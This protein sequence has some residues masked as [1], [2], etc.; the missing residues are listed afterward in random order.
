[1]L[2]QQFSAMTLSTRMR[3]C[4]QEL[5]LVTDVKTLPPIKNFCHLPLPIVCVQLPWPLLPLLIF[6]A[7]L[8]TVSLPP[9][10]PALFFSFLQSLYEQVLLLS[11]HPLLQLLSLFLQNN[12][13]ISASTLL[14]MA[15]F[16][17]PF[18]FCLCN[19]NAWSL[20]QVRTVTNMITQPNLNN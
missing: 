18:F 17:L 5:V 13:F 8:S 12:S 10:S 11:F 16:A 14:Q 1:M 9:I 19:I 6:P 2:F 20:L 7:L 3:K 15:A 4:R